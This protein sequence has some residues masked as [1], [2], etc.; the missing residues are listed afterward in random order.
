MIIK[1]S[2]RL[3]IKNLLLLRNVNFLIGN[4]TVLPLGSPSINKI[5]VWINNFKSDFKEA[6]KSEARGFLK[7]CEIDGYEE[8]LAIMK[9]ISS[10]ENF[11]SDFET[12]IKFINSV[13][14]FIRE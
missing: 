9:D 8:G 3:R 14:L 2:S 10:N 12:Y 11:N 5:K 13:H 7:V 6:G 4:G 1:K